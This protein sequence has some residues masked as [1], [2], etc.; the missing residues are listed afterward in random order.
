MKLYEIFD[1]YDLEWTNTL[2]NNIFLKN[3]QYYLT[4]I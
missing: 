3:P 1:I 4:A 2:V